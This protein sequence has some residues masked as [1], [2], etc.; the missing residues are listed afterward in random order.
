MTSTLTANATAFGACAVL[1]ACAPRAAC[2]ANAPPTAAAVSLPTPPASPPLSPDGSAK[3]ERQKVAV[4]PI[5]DDDLFREERRAL[6]AKLAARIASVLPTHDVVSL[7]AVDAKLE[8]ISK[9]GARCAYE[10]VPAARRVSGQGWLTTDVIHVSG[11]KTEPERLW[12]QL[13]DWQTVKHTLTGGWDP[14]L[15]RVQRYEQ[16]VAALVPLPEG[17]GL[18]GGLGG[19]FVPRGEVTVGA[20]TLCQRHG[21]HDCQPAT[22]AFTDRA[23]ELSACFAGA[24]DERVKLLFEGSA[25][26]ELENLDD[27]KGAAGRREA[28]LCAALSKSA[29]V[30][31]T[32]GRSQLVLHYEAKELVGKARPELRVVDASSN[33]HASDDWHTVERKVDGKSNY[34]SVRRLQ[35]DNLDALAPS[36]ARCGLAAG[37]LVVAELAVSEAGA[38][39][40]SRVITG[41]KNKRD[42]VC[43]DKA[44]TAAAFACTGDG[45]PATVR[46]AISWQE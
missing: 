14:K 3:K 5:E 41:A 34:S 18:L 20:L 30:T 46:L 45:K 29:G 44:L 40:K 7:T 24:D 28:C 10:A 12:V 26:C 8:P 16:A 4:L 39:Q 21:F 19:R 43:I 15:E 17:G 32:Q 35:V 22:K 11:F 9:A 13:S 42:S 37:S 2:P 33:L 23:S 31:A 6:R 36:L 1:L 27:V 38:V 25:R